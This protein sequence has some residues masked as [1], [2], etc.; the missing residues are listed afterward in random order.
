MDNLAFNSDTL[1]INATG[2]WGIDKGRQ[3]SAFSIALDSSDLEKT[4]TLFNHPGTMENGTGRIDSDIRWNAPPHAFSF[5]KL[6]GSVRLN[7]RKGRLLGVEPGAGRVFGLLGTLNFNDL[8]SKGFTFDRIEG[9]FV[10]KD[11]NASTDNLMMD[12]PAAKVEIK[13]RVGLAARDYDH[14][15]TVTP[16]S[17]TTLPL[18]GALAGDCRWGRRCCC[19]EAVSTGT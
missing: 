18:A 6:N 15:V 19:S 7:F 8:F 4:F 1:K 12:G 14:R 5:D 9:A 3:S 13:G 2:D 10:I 17:S 11:G 16:R